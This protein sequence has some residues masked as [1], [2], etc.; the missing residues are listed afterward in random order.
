MLIC[1]LRSALFRLD[2]KILCPHGVTP[3]GQARTKLSQSRPQI[4]PPFRSCP[5]R[6]RDTAP[7]HSWPSP[8]SLGWSLSSPDGLLSSL[9]YCHIEGSSVESLGLHC[10]SVCPQ[11]SSPWSHDQTVMAASI[12]SEPGGTAYL[13]DSFPLVWFNPLWSED[14]PRLCRWAKGHFII[15]LDSV[16]FIIKSYQ[17]YF[18]ASW[19]VGW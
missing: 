8:V 5:S 17:R 16:F 4:C 11:A 15:T 1:I 12:C 7:A 19:L 6:F 9:S 2:S 18:N 13:R 3:L 14:L 10:S